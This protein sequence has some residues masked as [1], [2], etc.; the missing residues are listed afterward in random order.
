MSAKPENS[1]GNIELHA[2]T[3]ST[4]PGWDPAQAPDRAPAGAAGGPANTVETVALP[5]V[6]R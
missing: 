6:S 3:P 5:R 2:G 4:S 1:L